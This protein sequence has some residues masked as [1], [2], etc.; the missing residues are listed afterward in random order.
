M[1]AVGEAVGATPGCCCWRR[2]PESPLGHGALTATSLQSSSPRTHDAGAANGRVAAS[3]DH[4]LRLDAAHG[5]GARRDGSQSSGG[6]CRG[7]ATARS[8]SSSSGACGDIG[9][10]GRVRVE[11]RLLWQ[12]D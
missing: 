4:A 5:L 6:G 10:V 2:R 11:R 8:G 9:S 1:I 12:E 3:P 7:E